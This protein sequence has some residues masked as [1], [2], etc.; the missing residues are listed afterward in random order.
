LAHD[1]GDDVT[2]VVLHRLADTAGR[3]ARQPGVSQVRSRARRRRWRAVTAAVGLAAAV[4]AFPAVIAG[5]GSAEAIP[6]AAG[7]ASAAPEPE[8]PIP[9]PASAEAS[10]EPTPKAERSHAPRSPAPSAGTQR[11][12]VWLLRVRPDQGCPQVVSVDRD[13]LL[14]DGVAKQAVRALLDGP[15]DAERAQGFTSAFEDDAERFRYLKLSG[16]RATADFTSLDV[17][18]ADDR[19]EKTK[20]LEPLERTLEQFSWIKEARFS[21]RGD[22]RAFYVG[23]LNDKVP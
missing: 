13:V 22:E 7:I 10:V 8:R 14:T 5:V 1:D 19:C 21:I 3:T 23:V 6:A 15:T 9:P 18:A 2:R 20:L 16:S 17:L 11:V 12:R 4:A